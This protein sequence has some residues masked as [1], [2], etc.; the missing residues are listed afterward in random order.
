MKIN[1]FCRKTFYDTLVENVS[2]EPCNRRVAR[3]I[4]L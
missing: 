4:A 3:R 2:A 1:I